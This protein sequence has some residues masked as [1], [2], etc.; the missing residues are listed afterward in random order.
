METI[1]RNNCTQIGFIQKPHGINGELAFLFQEEFY[2]TVENATMLFIEIENLLVPF[3]ILNEGIRFRT[4]DSALIKLQWIENER[5]ASELSGCK[6]FIHSSE[7]LSNPEVFS[8]NALNGFIVIDQRKTQ[9]GT[10]T[11]TSNYSGNI[12]L[13]V[14]RQG[15]ELLIP[16]NEDLLIQFDQES[17]TIALDLP[18]GL[19]TLDED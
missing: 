12:L 7:V 13:E 17:K 10:I 5:H 18:D 16:F 2:E 19:L 8:A 11:G 6:V 3:F 4:A 15:K 1:E 9:I 14:E